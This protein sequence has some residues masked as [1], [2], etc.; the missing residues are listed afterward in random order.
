MNKAVY[1]I[2]ALIIIVAGVACTQDR[3]KADGE[4]IVTPAAHQTQAPPTTVP[5]YHR[6]T[7]S[8]R[9]PIAQSYFH[10]YPLACGNCH[11]IPGTYSYTD[12]DSKTEIHLH[13]NTHSPSVIPG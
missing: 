5:P 4:Q 3:D 12:P 7:D 1:L 11:T 6:T 10:S 2:Y 13:A 9:H 8:N